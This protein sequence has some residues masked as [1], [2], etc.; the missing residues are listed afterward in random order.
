MTVW[1]RVA[2]RAYAGQPLALAVVI[3]CLPVPA[4]A[5]EPGQAETAA[6]RHDRDSTPKLLELGVH[7]GAPERLSASITGAFA[8]GDSEPNGVPGKM[9]TIRAAAGRGG[10]SVGIGHRVPLYGPFGPEV[11]MTVT[12]TS[13]SPRGGTGRST[14]VGLEVGYVSLGRVS[15]GV[16]RQVDGPSDRRDTI[17]TWGVGV[18]IPYGFWRW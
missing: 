7:Y 9:L 12:R 14:Y 6:A 8:Y 13:S 18:Q 3:V 15:I 4:L 2:G 11:L 5:Q 17:L 16:A 10:F 1:R